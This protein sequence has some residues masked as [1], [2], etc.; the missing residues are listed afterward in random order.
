MNRQRNVFNNL[1]ITNDHLTKVS[2]I[3][4]HKIAKYNKHFLE[5]DFIKDGMIE[6]ATVINPEKIEQYNNL[7]LSRRTAVRRIECIAKNIQPQ[8]KKKI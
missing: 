1:F 4:S 5:G 3:I 8:L 2:Y 6:S 7:S